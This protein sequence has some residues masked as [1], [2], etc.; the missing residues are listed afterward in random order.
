MGFIEMG[1][2]S[3]LKTPSIFPEGEE[4]EK[5]DAKIVFYKNC[6]LVELL[7]KKEMM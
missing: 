1:S 6:M 4:K 2:K 3:L 5:I 7:V